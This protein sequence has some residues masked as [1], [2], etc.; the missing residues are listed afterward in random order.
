MSD[1]L[2]RAR[3]YGQLS[4]LG[5]GRIPSAARKPGEGVT[6]R[7][8]VPLTR[9]A[10]RF[11]RCSPT[12]PPR[13]EVKIERNGLQVRGQ[14][15]WAFPRFAAAGANLTHPMWQSCGIA[16]MMK[17]EPG[18]LRSETIIGLYERHARDWDR[19]RGR[20]LFER[21]WLDRFIALLPRGACLLDLGCGSAEPIDRHLIE[22]GFLLTGVDSSPT[23]ISL[24]RARFPQHEW[25]VA[26]MRALALERTF[27]GVIAWDSFF[28]LSHA[29]QRRTFS[30]FRPNF[31]L[32]KPVS[33]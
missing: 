31:P 13:G 12:C 32:A 18:D 21:A 1:F 26:D 25:I 11:V 7:V 22:R 4:P 17:D 28:H 8:I 6:P 10:S 23:L 14:A 15:G 3:T 27:H 9:R 16:A 5:R 20:N 29:H 19:D 2:T 33:D 24:C 30:L